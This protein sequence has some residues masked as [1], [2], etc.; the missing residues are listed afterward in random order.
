LIQIDEFEKSH[1]TPAPL[2]YTLEPP[3]PSLTTS[4]MALLLSLPP[5]PPPPS[6]PPPT[7]T[8]DQTLQHFYAQLNCDQPDPVPSLS[9]MGKQPTIVTKSESH[10]HHHHHKDKKSVS[11]NQS[12]SN[13][14]Y[15]FS[16]TETIEKLTN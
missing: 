12:L 13:H 5:P 7:N 14:F 15:Y 10:H 1:L 11:Q 16:L 4:E 2:S 8:N 9:D 3:K 6:P